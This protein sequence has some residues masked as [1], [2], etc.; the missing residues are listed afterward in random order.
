[1]DTKSIIPIP[2][3]P[4][5]NGNRITEVWFRFLLQLFNRT[6]ASEG[7]DLTKVIRDINDLQ[8]NLE[9]QEY[10]AAIAALQAALSDVPPDVLTS[11]LIEVTALRVADIEAQME[12][13]VSSVS[14]PGAEPPA[15]VLALVVREDPP[16]D[17]YTHGS[18]AG[19]DLHAVASPMA[20]GFMSAADK[21]KLDVYPRI[22]MSPVAVTADVV[23]TNSTADVNILTGALPANQLAV[24]STFFCGFT[25]ITSTHNSVQTLNI[26]AKIGAT[27]IIILSLTYPG[28]GVTNVGVYTQLRMT[29][30]SIGAGGTVQ[31]SGISQGSVS[32]LTNAPF[33]A[34]TSGAIDTTV[35]NSLTI[36]MNWGA[37][38]PTNVA[39]TK[40]G[41]LVQDN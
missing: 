40:T 12:A 27:K 28:S 3:A 20:A 33:I 24:G 41:L 39:T 13:L 1:M 29:V 8:A 30:R 32:V 11:A 26:W 6:G 10:G 4:L 9:A 25:T 15:D 36:G 2:D 18:Q 17:V 38:Q 37:V 34:S 7:G 19:G 23:A 16:A 31:I 21:S 22:A 35:A 5:V 14:T